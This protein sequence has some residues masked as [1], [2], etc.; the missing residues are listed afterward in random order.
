MKAVQIEP[1]LLEHPDI[2]GLV[3]LLRDAVAHGAS[4]GFIHGLTSTDAREYWTKVLADFAA[5]SRMI[6]IAKDSA[7]GSVVGSVQLVFENRRNGR[8]RAEVQKLLVLKSCRRHRIGA[9]LMEI[10]ENAALQR[11]ISLLFLDT[12]E[13]HG[14]ARDFYDALGYS[15]AGGIPGYAIDPDGKPSKNAIFYKNLPPL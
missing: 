8:H 3:A 14:G 11:Q 13:G 10:L 12:S 15:Y 2:D 7:D 4:V 6:W 5:G 9:R 1:L